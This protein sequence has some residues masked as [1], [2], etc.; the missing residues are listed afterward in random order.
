[1]RAAARISAGCVLL[2]AGLTGRRAA[3]DVAELPYDSPYLANAAII[4]LM[5]DVTLYV[6]YDNESMKP[7]LAAGERDLMRQHPPYGVK[8]KRGAPL[9]AYGP[10]IVG[11]ALRA[12]SGA[13][14]YAAEGNIRLHANGAIAFWLKPVDWTGTGNSYFFLLPGGNKMGVMRQALMKN[15]GG[16]ILRHEGF[17]VYARRDPTDTRGAAGR[18]RGERFKE[19]EWHL[20]VVNWAW[21]NVSMSVDGGPFDAGKSLTGFPEWKDAVAWFY[22]GSRGGCP[23][24]MD[25]A[26]VFSRPLD[27]TEARL[28]HDTV[29]AWVEER[30]EGL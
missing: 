26:M 28:I 17:L 23:T 18:W 2:A 13:G 30:G 8:A 5:S 24:L 19:G 27:V 16:K 12:D 22:L 20:V 10:G 25:E 21:P 4:E 29:R 3:A 7:E 9:G 15:E 11:K 14:Q 1:M 6:S